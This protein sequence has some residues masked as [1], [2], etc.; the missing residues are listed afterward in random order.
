MT[1]SSASLFS[2][3]LLV[4]PFLAFIIT[5]LNQFFIWQA[6]TFH[7]FWLSDRPLC[8]HYVD[9]QHS[10]T[11]HPWAHWHAQAPLHQYLNFKIL[12]CVFKSLHDLIPSQYLYHNLALQPSKSSALLEF[13]SGPPTPILHT[14]VAF[15]GVL[16]L[17][18]CLFKPLHFPHTAPWR[19]SLNLAFY[20]PEYLDSAQSIAS[21]A[22]PTKKVASIIKNF[23]QTG[24]VLFLLLLWAVGTEAYSHT[25][26]DSGAPTLLQPS[27]S[28][29]SLHNPSST[30]TVEH[31]APFHC[32][33]LFF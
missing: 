26:P 28:C 4:K 19:P 18:N 22:L 5:G 27:G 20:Q 13:W 12:S 8:A 21:T 10:W 2:S 15:V 3:F 11:H 9:L 14:T 1:F 16:S 29:C 30:L 31:F 23:Q 7:P 24:H 6:S 25:P 32:Y 17:W 33:E